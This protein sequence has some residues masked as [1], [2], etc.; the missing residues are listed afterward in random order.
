MCCKYFRVSENRR[1]KICNSLGGVLIRGVTFHIISK[2]KVRVILCVWLT[3]TDN[4]IENV[5]FFRFMVV[6]LVMC[7]TQ[8]SLLDLLR[9]FFSTGG[10][11]F[12]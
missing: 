7:K 3:H 5:D 9:N 4:C 1:D 8:L 6:L 2:D 10:G 12:I 11:N